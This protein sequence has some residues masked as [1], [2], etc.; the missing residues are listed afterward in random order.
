MR[1]R[2][3]DAVDVGGGGDRPWWTTVSKRKKP[4]QNGFGLAQF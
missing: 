1:E 2:R 4:S 3:G